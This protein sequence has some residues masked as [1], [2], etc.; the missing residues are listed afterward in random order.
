MHPV[1]YNR[2]CYRIIPM[3]IYIL[4]EIVGYLCVGWILRIVLLERHRGKEGQ[5]LL[6]WDRR[7]MELAILLP[8]PKPLYFLY[9]V[10]LVPLFSFL[11]Y[12]TWLFTFYY[13]NSY[14]ISPF[15]PRS[16]VVLYVWIT[17]K[18]FQYEPG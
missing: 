6:G 16:I 13:G 8:Y 11:F 18:V 5:G 12:F 15:C 1:L 4:L 7:R 14:A 10:F 9:L 17:K 2:C 3:N